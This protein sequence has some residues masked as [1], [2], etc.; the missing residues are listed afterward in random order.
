MKWLMYSGV[1][2][3][4]IV[5]PFHWRFSWEVIKPDDLNPKRYMLFFQLLLLNIRIVFD[6]GSW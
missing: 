6:D 5:N 3:T 4:L 2:V 1:W